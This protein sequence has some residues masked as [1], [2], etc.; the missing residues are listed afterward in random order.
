[1]KL[2]MLVLILC[3]AFFGKVFA[4]YNSSNK[5]KSARILD[6]NYGYMNNSNFLIS[7][8][9]LLYNWVTKVHYDIS[10]DIVKNFKTYCDVITNLKVEQSSSSGILYGANFQVF[11]PTDKNSIYGKDKAL[12]NQGGNIF[13]ITPYGKFSMGYQQG[14]ESLIN[15]NKFFGD[16]SQGEDATFMKYKSSD[17]VDMMGIDRAIFY[18]MLYSEGLF[19]INRAR[20]DMYGNNMVLNNIKDFISGL[21]FRLSYYSPNLMGFKFGLS[22]SPTGYNKKIFQDKK[23]NMEKVKEVQGNSNIKADIKGSHASFSLSDDGTVEGSMIFNVNNNASMVIKDAKDKV[24]ISERN[25]VTS[26]KFGAYYDNI[27]SGIASYSFIFQDLQCEFIISGEYAKGRQLQTLLFGDL[28]GISVANSIKF[29]NKLKLYG[30]YGYLGNSG[31]VYS[32]G[33]LSR[34]KISPSYYWVIGLGYQYDYLYIS[35]SYFKSRKNS[36]SGSIIDII[37]FNLGVDY[38][39]NQNDS[40]V[41]YSIFSYYHLMVYNNFSRDISNNVILSGIR[42]TF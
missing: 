14:V 39:L 22:Y 34:N 23:F 10:D 30:S 29:F 38:R 20:H 21:P 41:S 6:K 16:H 18:P 32:Q 35:G 7:G 4:G 37:D 24:I 9:V 5:L 25:G 27:I 15:R 36:P 28:L 8:Q 40:K 31:Q 1:M 17:F 11:I 33:L 2:F 13:F 3:S 26:Y 12:I 42:L 19:Y